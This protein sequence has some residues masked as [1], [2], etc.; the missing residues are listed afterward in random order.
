MNINNNLTEN[1]IDKI[2][3]KSQL[4]HQLQIP[5]TK[6]TVWIFDKIN[7]MKIRFYKTG[8]LN[9]SNYVK[10]L[11]RSNALINIK[12]NVKYCFL[13]S[14]LAYLHTSDNDHPI[15]VSNYIQYFNE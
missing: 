14:L 2:D 3:I 12:N 4:E 5:E 9:G 10:I 7:S 8:E 13:W 15:G 1:D 6:E 11:L